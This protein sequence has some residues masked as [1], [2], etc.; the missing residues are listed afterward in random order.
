MMT[1]RIR[2]GLAMTKVLTWTKA[3]AQ[4]IAGERGMLHP[5]GVKMIGG[6][7]WGY[8]NDKGEF[9]IRPQY[10]MA[11]PYQANGLAV[12]ATA[13]GSGIIDGHGHYVVAPQYENIGAFAE[14]RAVVLAAEGAMVINEQGKVITKQPYSFI[15]A[16][17]NGRAIFQ[18]Q[19]AEGFLYGYL[20]QQGEKVIPAQFQ[21]ANAF[22]AGKAVVKLAEN[23]FALIDLNGE[24]LQQYNY[25]DV[26]PLGEGL[27]AFRQDPQGRYGYID[28][29]GNVVIAPRF[30]S[31]AVFADGRAIVNVAADYAQNQYGLIDKQGNYIIKP[32]YNFILP[33]GAERFAVGV[34][35]DQERPYLGSRYG[36][37]DLNGK[38]LT[39]FLYTAVGEYR[40]GL[41]SATDDQ[42]TFFLDQNGKRVLKLPVVRGA[43]TLALEGNLVRVDVDQRLSYRDQKGKVIWQ[44]PTVIPLNIRYRVQEKKYKPNKDY[45]V[46]YPQVLGLA[47][48][49]APRVNAKLRELAGVKPI[50]PRGQ[51]D[52]SYT[53]DFEVIF[54]KKHLLV[55]NLSGYN[56]PFG[57][58]HGMP[59][60]IYPHIN[61]VTGEFYNLAALFRKDSNY[62]KVLSEIIA[63]QIKTNPEYSYVWPEQYKG[64]AA[65][66]PFYV[67]EDALYIYF[68]PYEIAPYAA[69]F[70]TFR[71]PYTA[72]MN[73]IDTAGEFW[74]AFH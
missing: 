18:R 70:P 48:T 44:P 57:A 22:A 7:R 51:L 63:Q 11:Y 41:A 73:I 9:V 34:P 47:P 49:I 19:A 38:Q 4:K 20:D 42:E 62:V 2:E 68:T 55:L 36:I 6:R 71:I 3:L 43:G 29:Q 45:L 35:V 40:A 67:T 72:I 13:D 12:V 58:A 15:S 69:G 54:F 56:Y 1:M 61:L 30:L 60:E 74:Q 24:I 39:D 50:D 25:H 31:A 64:I 27:L 17:V 46:Y 26:G 28:I 5:A 8:V 32:Q 21:Y 52:Y 10:L 65:N 53:G 59:S 23:R 37:F 33:L 14:G 16:Y 66:Q